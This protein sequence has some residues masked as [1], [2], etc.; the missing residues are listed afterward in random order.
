V[1]IV[2]RRLDR[3]LETWLGRWPADGPGLH[4]VASA[5]RERPGW[6]GR[7][8]PA[9]G[10]SDPVAGVLSVAAAHA[11][12]VRALAGLPVHDL[13]ARLPAAIGRPRRHAYRAVFRWTTSPLAL[14][15]AGTWLPFDHPAVPEWLRPFGGDV[16]VALDDGTGEYLAG[17]GIKRHDR[18]GH[19]LAV[20]TVP[21]VRGRGLGRRLVSQAAR[22][23]LD[24]GAVPTY[25]HDP[26]NAA[27]ARVAQ[28]AGFP[29][30]GWTALG[31]GD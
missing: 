28:A 12:P 14:P 1:I 3:H 27:S 6:D 18:Y 21:A 7:I 8:H 4:V 10:V 22:R 23:V 16:L 11:D 26:A 24:D 13:L 29:D 20:G 2:D 15:D 17:V 9:I 25:V 30:L 5:R 31:A 19:E